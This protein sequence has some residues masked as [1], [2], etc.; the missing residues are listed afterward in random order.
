MELEGYSRPMYNKL[1]HSAIVGVIHKLTVDEV[2]DHSKTPMTCCC[3][4]FYVQNLEITHMTLTTPTRGQSVMTRL[5]LHVANP[6]TKFE[7]SSLSH[8]GDI[9]HTRLTALFPGLPG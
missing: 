9:S 6:Y 1:V 4:I 3:E 7:V 2:V 5:M 8:S